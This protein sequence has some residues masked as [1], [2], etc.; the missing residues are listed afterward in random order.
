MRNMLKTGLALHTATAEGSYPAHLEP[1]QTDYCALPHTAAQPDGFTR[2]G[3]VQNLLSM[4]QT[5]VLAS[6]ND[7]ASRRRRWLSSLGG[8]PRLP[9]QRP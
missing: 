1:V 5:H 3:A 2:P 9:S 4:Q 6:S 8:A 7:S